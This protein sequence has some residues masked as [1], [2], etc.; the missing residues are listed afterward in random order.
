MQLEGLIHC[1]DGL[2]A[3]NAYARTKT[4]NLGRIPSLPSSY[5]SAP[6]DG[7]YDA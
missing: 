2:L 1:P 5:T 7:F 4:Q 6:M 3:H